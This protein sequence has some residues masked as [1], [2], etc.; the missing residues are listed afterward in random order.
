[1][2]LL[3]VLFL[4]LSPAWVSAQEFLRG[5]IMGL[6]EGVEKPLGFAT[7]QWLNTT[8]GAVA[9]ESGKF[10]IERNAASS[11]LIVSY[12]GFTSD[13]F[14]TKGLQDIH[15]VLKA[16]IELAETIVKGDK[17]A[18]TIS[19]ISNMKTEILGKGELKKA[20]CC[21][22]SES[23]ETNPTVEVS[24]SDALTGIRQI[25]MLGLSGIYAQTLVENVPMLHGLNASTGLSFIPGPFVENIYLSKGA[26]SVMYGFES[27]SGQINVELIKPEEAPKLYLN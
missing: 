11:L 24:F 9:D 18:T 17:K 14:E 25:Q 13:T 20:A 5:R 6:E 22:L 1:M 16:N 26:G 15:V 19:S 2:K 23:F 12:T 10:S 8:Q 7:V 3:S 21:N 27:M 4:L